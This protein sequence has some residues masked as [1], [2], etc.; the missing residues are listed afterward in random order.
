MISYYVE[1]RKV[2]TLSLVICEWHFMKLYARRTSRLEQGVDRLL[3][4]LGNWSRSS[5]FL[6]LMPG[7]TQQGM[8]QSSSWNFQDEVQQP[9]GARG[10]GGS[11]AAPQRSAQAVRHW[12]SHWQGEE[13]STP[14]LYFLIIAAPGEIIQHFK[15]CHH[16][17]TVSLAGWETNDS[18]HFRKVVSSISRIG[19]IIFISG[20]CHHPDNRAKQ[21]WKEEEAG[22][23]PE[24]CQF[25]CDATLPSGCCWTESLTEEENQSWLHKHW[26]SAEGWEKMPFFHWVIAEWSES[27]NTPESFTYLC[28]LVVL[29]LVE[30]CNFFCR[31]S[32][33]PQTCKSREICMRMLSETCRRSRLLTNHSRKGSKQNSK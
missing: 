24:I 3:R 20:G 27:T 12:S 32:R 5:G 7:S 1:M 31:S 21:F 4:I 18:F 8:G 13:I 29:I 10:C 19:S 14:E 16:S 22:G 25:R 28:G 6:K 15:K 17:P 23:L 11:G 33:R 30:L 9:G 26:C 2:F